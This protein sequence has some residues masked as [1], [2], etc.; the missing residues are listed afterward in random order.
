[1]KGKRIFS[2]L[3]VLALLASLLTVSAFAAESKTLTLREDWRLTEDLDLA[4]PAG[5]TLTIDGNGHHI[6]ELGGMLKNSGAGDV[7]FVNGT[8]LYPIGASESCTTATSNA[9]MAE[10]K[11][12]SSTGGGTSTGGGGGGGGSTASSTTTTETVTNPDGSTTT[13]VTDKTTGTV[14]E[15]TKYTDGSTTTT[16][17]ANGQVTTQV[18]LSQAALDAAQASGSSVTL[19]MPAV[20]ASSS[21]AGAPSVTVDLPGAAS[22]Q[23]EIPVSNLTPGTVA[24]LVAADGTERVIK[25]TLATENGIAVTLSD[26]DTVK[27]VDNTKTFSDVPSGYWGADEIAFAA[28]R[29][30]FQGTGDTTFA[31]EVPMSRAMMLTVLARYNGVD[32]SKGSTWYEAGAAWA[33]ETG[34]SDGTNLDGALTREQL[35]LM[36]YRYAGEPAAAGSLSAF[37]DAENVSSWAVQAMVWATENGLINGVGGDLLNPQGQATRAQVA[38]IL[39]RFVT[40]VN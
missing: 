27:V 34:I 2:L 40:L 8:I 29:E 11:T 9:L 14:T 25:T 1:M 6:Y 30:L 20:A 24:V 19:P 28:S 18:K 23:V 36:L 31:P 7:T 4:V 16:V 32:T 10:R 39:A 3:T 26:G 38:A 12:G 5:T 37:G 22:A 33:V 17:T 21:A 15:T 13:T 35:A